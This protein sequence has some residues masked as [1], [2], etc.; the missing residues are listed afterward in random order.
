V[1]GSSGIVL[2]AAGLWSY[3]GPSSLDDRIEAEG[4]LVA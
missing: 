3:Q 1:E 4:G 2:V